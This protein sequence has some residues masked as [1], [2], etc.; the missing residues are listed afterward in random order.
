MILYR[1][2]CN[3][4]CDE[5]GWRWYLGIWVVFYI[6]MG[7]ITHGNFNAMQN[8]LYAFIILNLVGCILNIM[9]I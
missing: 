2:F 6:C 3:W 8:V 7:V 1:K 9:S 4:I 5:G